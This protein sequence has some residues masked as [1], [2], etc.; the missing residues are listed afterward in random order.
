[1]RPRLLDLFC[2]AG[3]ASR[4]YAAAGFDVHGVDMDSARLRH[5][6][7][8]H[9]RAD[10]MDV[11]K[12]KAYLDTF[13][14]IAASPPCQAYS[15][16]RHS[17]NATHPDLL[18]Q[19]LEALADRLYCIENVVGAPLPN[20]LILCGTMFGL[21]AHDPAYG[22]TVELRRHR[23][24]GSPLL[25]YPPA[26]CRHGRHPVA[27]V[28]GGGSTDRNH[29][30]NVRRGGY[31]PSPAVAKSIMGLDIP[32]THLTQAIPPAYTEWIGGQLIDHLRHAATESDRMSHH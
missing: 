32:W 13:D 17:H 4:G 7:Y 11:L 20:P 10:V 24:F 27:G 28:Y 19:V 2:G 5:Y 16:T 25:L 30:V 21:T 15:V 18:P 14:V 8:P 31:T 9:T 1:V 6:P 12:D 29:A 3:G 22:G 26:P 23:L